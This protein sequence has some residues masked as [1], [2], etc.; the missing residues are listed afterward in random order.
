MISDL[1]GQPRA[2]SSPA[3]DMAEVV[4]VAMALQYDVLETEAKSRIEARG[5][6]SLLEG[7][8]ICNQWAH[9]YSV[10]LAQ[11]QAA[12]YVFDC[13]AP[14]A[15]MLDDETTWGRFPQRL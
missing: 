8:H 10:A 9:V 6:D 11:V 14:A 15:A 12:S 1:G 7:G 5:S 2:D 3:L 13:A 4:V